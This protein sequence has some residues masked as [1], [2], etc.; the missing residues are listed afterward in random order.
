M[1][2]RRPVRRL[3]RRNS[4]SE[5]GSFQSEVGSS[6]SEDWTFLS[7][8]TYFLTFLERLYLVFNLLRIFRRLNSLQGEEYVVSNIVIPSGIAYD[9]LDV[10]GIRG[11]CGLISDPLGANSV[12]AVCMG[13]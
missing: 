12:F 10:S 8:K 3:V 2:V 13:V 4:Q 5:V 6:P 9:F 11:L 7:S 1:L